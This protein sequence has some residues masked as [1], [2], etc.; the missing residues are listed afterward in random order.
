MKPATKRKKTKRMKSDMPQRENSSQGKKTQTLLSEERNPLEGNPRSTRQKD[1][2]AAAQ[3]R[4]VLI[5][6]G[7]TRPSLQGRSDHAS[8]EKIP[9][10]EV[11]DR[12]SHM[13]L[14]MTE[15][16]LERKLIWRALCHTVALTQPAKGMFPISCSFHGSIE[17]TLDGWSSLEMAMY[18]HQTQSNT[19]HC[20]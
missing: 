5:S 6:S 19:N 20:L 9:F 11:R 15:K 3:N 17:S 18:T 8:P 1:S 12:L 4:K 14:Q 13:C 16:S 2:A 10:S 7:Q